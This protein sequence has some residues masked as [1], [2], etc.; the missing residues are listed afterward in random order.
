MTAKFWVGGT[1]T[2]DNATTTNWSLSTGGA[3]GA[4]VPAAADTVTFDASSGAGTCTVAATINGSNTIVSLTC[5]AM[6]MTLDFS[7]NNPSVTMVTMSISGAGTR[8]VKLG[9]GTFTLT[10]NNT[11]NMFDASTITGLTL[12]AGTSTINFAPSSAPNGSWGLASGGL[13]G[14]NALN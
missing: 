12:T 13:N 14:A 11:S 5:G 1:G 4:A 2:W 8:T 7:V 3:G 6:G 9:S 10:S